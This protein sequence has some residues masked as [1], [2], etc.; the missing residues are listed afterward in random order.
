[1]LVRD[2]KYIPSQDKD[3]F[4]LL[5]IGLW[6]KV[7]EELSPSPDWDY[8]YRLSKEQTVLGLIADGIGIYRKEHPELNITTEQNDRFV[9]ASANI[10]FRNKA[11]NELQSKLCQLFDDPSRLHDLFP[12]SE[13]QDLPN[14]LAPSLPHSL[15]PISYVVLKGQAVGQYYPKPMLRVSGDIDFFF[16]EENY[17]RAKKLLAFISST[18]EKEQLYQSHVE[19][20]INDIEIELHAGE[21]QKLGMASKFN[22]LLNEMFHS[23]QMRHYSCCGINISL[24]PATFEATYIFI[25]FIKHYYKKGIGLRQLCDWVMQLHSQK[26]GIYLEELNNNICGF[27]FENQWNK[28][29]DFA[30]SSLSFG[31]DDYKYFKIINSSTCSFNIFDK[32]NHL[33]AKSLS[34]DSIWNQCKT[35]GNFGR[36]EQEECE[37]KKKEQSK[38]LFIRICSYIASMHVNFAEDVCFSLFLAFRNYFNAIVYYLMIAKRKLFVK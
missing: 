20:T 9:E 4:I 6:Q 15:N 5:R 21:M 3:F 25:H 7:E 22:R 35:K 30:V 33:F 29:L 2:N 11:V 13:P 1:M 10:M 28:F 17:E 37:T 16:D 34:Q 23:G 38:Y 32:V 27:H 19:Y 26:E 12:Q 14:S 8:I 31:E 18:D 24:A 36:K